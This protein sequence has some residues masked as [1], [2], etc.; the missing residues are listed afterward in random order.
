MKKTLKFILALCLILSLS[1]SVF[2]KTTVVKT[3]VYLNNNK[4]SF[5]KPV[6]N[7]DGYTYFPMRELLNDLGVN[8]NNIIWDSETKSVTMHANN[9]ITIFLVNS[10]EVI[11]NGKKVKI[12]S[13]PVIYQGSTYLPI[14]PVADACGL[15][16][17]YN[18]AN[19]SIYLK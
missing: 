8:D 10:N 5:S 17:T 18:S 14:R 7:I 2:A 13:K 4:L 15:E 3:D 12:D 1:T 6:L 11:Q 19:K 9:T 16:T